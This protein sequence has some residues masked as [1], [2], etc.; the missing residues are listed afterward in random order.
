MKL[1]VLLS[2]FPYPLEKG[3]KLRA[4]HQIREL[5]KHHE[6]H[7]CCLSDTEVKDEWKKE[8]EHYC[9][10]I[11]VHQLTKLKVWFNT[12]IQ[13]FS[14]KPYQVGYFYQKSIQRKINTQIQSLQPDHI[15]CQLI[16]TS[17]YVK[18]FHD[19]NKTIDYQ[20]ALSK[21]MFRRAEIS[22]G[23][24]KSIFTTEGKRLSAYENRIF[25]YFQHHTIISEQDRNFINH[26]E[27]GNIAIVENGISDEFFNYTGDVKK[28]HQIGFVGN[29]NYPP[30]I[31]CS[32]FLSSEILPKLNSDV[33]LL[34]AGA[35]PHQRIKDLASSQVKVTGWIEDIRDAYASIEVFTAPLFVGTGLQNKLLEAMAMGIPV[36]TTPL[37]NNALKAKAG[38]HIL[39]AENAEEF[40]A[41]ITNLLNDSSLKEKITTN[42]KA[43]VRENYS[44]EKSVSK[45][46]QLF[47]Q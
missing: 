5:S 13:L 35:S 46:E 10:S 4:F 6:I 39:I 7:L 3:D 36:V 26:P 22:S 19:I 17:E 45:L 11:T 1:F 42:A 47:A 31:E 16:R 12:A 38:E 29:M 21:G 34:L 20:D 28:T 37:A 15:Y 44:W 8:L 41:H 2:R 14:D 24:K 23:I 25:D 32:E 9:E 43:F 40:A 18:N 27:S 33:Q 30:N